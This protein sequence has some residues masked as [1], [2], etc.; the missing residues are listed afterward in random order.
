M[1]GPDTAADDGAG[2]D[3]TGA[4]ADPLGAVDDDSLDDDG[5][6]DAG[7]PAWGDPD[8]HALTTRAPAAT[9]AT[10]RVVP[11]RLDLIHRP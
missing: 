5:A 9:H 8:V 7:G 3:V 2:C 10:R 6:D 4:D 11:T 1:G